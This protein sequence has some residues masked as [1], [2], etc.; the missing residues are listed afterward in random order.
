MNN[1]CYCCLFSLY[2][3]STHRR[4]TEFDGMV[5]IK[6]DVLTVVLGIISPTSSYTSIQK[7]PMNP[8]HVMSIFFI[9][10]ISAFL[11]ALDY[12]TIYFDPAVYEAA[13]HGSKGTFVIALII[14]IVDCWSPSLDGIVGPKKWI[15][16]IG[17]KGGVPMFSRFA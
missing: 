12:P 7:W 6:V 9:L 5:A 17:R 14:N 8:C 4:S 16:I 10:A 1:S 15:H 11:I 2:L 13:K 3:H